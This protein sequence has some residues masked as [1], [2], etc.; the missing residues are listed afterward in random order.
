MI[1]ADTSVWVAYFRASDPLLVAHLK[2]LLEEDQVAL[3]IP[4][5]LEMLCGSRRE[6]W[7]RLRRV[8][9]ALPLLFPTGTTWERIE[10]WIETAVSNGERFGVA[11]PL[12]AALA[13]DHEALLWSL[14]SDFERMQRLGFIRLHIPSKFRF[15]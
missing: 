4:V 14:D 2:G 6:E 12:I 15:R 7:M 9:S 3:A 1:L 5:K 13:A 10:G 11:D 8:L